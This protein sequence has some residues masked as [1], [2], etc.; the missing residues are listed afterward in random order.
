[1]IRFLPVTG[2]ENEGRYGWPPWLGPGLFLACAV[3]CPLTALAWALGWA[4]GGLLLG[5]GLLLHGVI[6]LGVLHL[7][8]GV[9]GRALIAG[10]ADRPLIAL[11]FDDG[12]DER[13]TPRVLEALA[14][15]GAPATFFVIGE[16]AARHGDLLREMARRGHQIENHSY[17]HAYTTPMRG[18]ARLR[19]ELLRTQEVIAEATGRLPVWFRPPVGLLSPRVAAAAAAAGLRL[20]GYGGKARDG[21]SGTTVADALR[22]LEPALRPG[23]ILVLHDA[24]ERG[25]RRPIA[26]EV[27]EALLPLL[28]ARGLRPVTLAELLGPPGP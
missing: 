24:A 25:D 21:L 13:D 8:S 14:R 6:A 20:C 17:D 22:H 10:P 9:F 4:G 26:A 18:V 16:R 28:A 1:M 12:P 5:A 11:T 15:H 23:A 27:L 7:P 19:D 3:L 2:K